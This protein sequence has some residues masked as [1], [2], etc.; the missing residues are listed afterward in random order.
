[1]GFEA[2]LAEGASAR[3]TVRFQPNLPRSRERLAHYPWHPAPESQLLAHHPYPVADLAQRAAQLTVQ[4]GRDGPAPAIP[5]ERCR[6]P[7][8][9]HVELDAGFEPGRSYAVTYSTRHV[10]IVG[11]GLLALRD[12]V[13]WLR[14]AH[15]SA[16]AFG[17]GVSQ[18]GRLL[19]EFLL[20]AHNLD[21]DGR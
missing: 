9:E 4:D 10:P 8:P 13:A 20:G 15:G 21:E 17:W 14:R 7:D 3:V 1:V 16:R 19:R 12:S 5:R 2:P 6:F 11:A 18:T